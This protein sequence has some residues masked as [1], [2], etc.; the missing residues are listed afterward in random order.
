MDDLKRF[1][2]V[3]EETGDIAAVLE[4]GIALPDADAIRSHLD[5]V[6][7]PDRDAIQLALRSAL[8]QAIALTATLETAQGSLK[9]QLDGLARSA[10]A[11]VA[12]GAASNRNKRS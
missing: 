6:P 12:Y 2:K 9:E 1:M 10:E 7:A 8:N 11:C 5:T 4:S 3:W